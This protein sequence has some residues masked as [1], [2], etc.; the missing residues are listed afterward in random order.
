MDD[1]TVLKRKLALSRS[2]LPGSSPFIRHAIINNIK[3]Y[4]RA[5]LAL[6]DAER[7]YTPEEVARKIQVNLY[8]RFKISGRK[9]YYYLSKKGLL[10]DG[11]V[12]D[13][14]ILDQLM[15]GILTVNYAV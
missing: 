15:D 14:I 3:L 1:I 11:K 6:E 8:Q 7:G 5:I 12:Q 13:P 2:I 4:R 9:D 10:V